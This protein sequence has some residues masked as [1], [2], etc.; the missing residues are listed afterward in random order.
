M[1]N[2]LK[3]TDGF[4]VCAICSEN[5]T[6]DNYYGDGRGGLRS[7][8]SSCNKI[9]KDKRK[10]QQKTAPIILSPSLDGVTALVCKGCATSKNIEEFRA[11]TVDNKIYRKFKCRVCEY[12]YKLK[13]GREKTKERQIEKQN[14]VK[15]RTSKVCT[16]C[17][18]D[19]PL[20][21]YYNRKDTYDS[22]EPRCKECC[23]IRNKDAYY[24]IERKP[25]D[26]LSKIVDKINKTNDNRKFTIYFI[27]NSRSIKIGRAEITES[28]NTVEKAIARRM[29]SM[30]SNNDEK[31]LLLGSTQV[32]DISTEVRIHHKFN[33]LRKTGEWFNYSPDLLHF[34]QEIQTKTTIQDLH[35]FIEKFEVEDNSK[36]ESQDISETQHIS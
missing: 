2:T 24:R 14:I 36:E 34:I 10:E 6:V 17:S 33:H 7:E 31:L 9:L 22:L 11:Y 18:V 21:E 35:D 32:G 4:K 13:R 3:I 8:C 12:E 23:S 26:K 30:Q 15:N 28:S 5:K 1:I 20:A 25:K 19:K 29:Y 16:T 27:D